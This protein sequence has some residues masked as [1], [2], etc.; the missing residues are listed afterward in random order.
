[1]CSLKYMYVKKITALDVRECLK[2]IKLGKAAGL[3]G[4][5]AE[6]LFFRTVLFVYIYLYYLRVS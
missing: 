3:D 5:A 2:N 1:M 6:H 4:L